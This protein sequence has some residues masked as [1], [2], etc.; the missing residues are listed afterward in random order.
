MKQNQYK[1]H[2]AYD[3]EEGFK[4]L[5]EYSKNAILAAW[6]NCHKIYLAMD[7]EKANFFR[8]NYETVVESSLSESLSSYVKDWFE[9]SCSLRFIN[10]V[11][12]NNANPNAG[13]VNIISQFAT[14]DKGNKT[15]K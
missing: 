8:E 7:Q 4:A 12:T 1:K 15:Y 3:I 13:Y 14:S 6:D 9:N 2:D 5:E 11:W 10:A